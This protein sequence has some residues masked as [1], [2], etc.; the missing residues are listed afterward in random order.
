MQSLKCRRSVKRSPSRLAEAPSQAESS[1]C[2]GLFQLK[3]EIWVSA[4]VP[5]RHHFNRGW[6]ALYAIVEIVLNFAQE[7]AAHAR[8]LDIGGGRSYG[9]L[10]AD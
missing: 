1:F 7:N 2:L 9:R 8:K 3:V 4:R 10:S 6:V 5:D